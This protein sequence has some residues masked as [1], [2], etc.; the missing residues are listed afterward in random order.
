M[1]VRT[2]LTWPD[3]RLLQSAEPVEAVDD[4][5]KTLVADMFETMYAQSGCGL[6]ATQLGIPLQVVVLDCGT[7]AEPEP[8]ALINARIVERDGEVVWNEGCLSLPGITA[9]VERAETVVVEALD[10]EGREIRVRAGGLA[11]VCI[12][13]ELDHLDGRLYVDRLG[14]LERLAALSD[15]DKA[16][17]AAAEASRPARA[18]APEAGR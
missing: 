7:D 4:P 13:H 2:V 11:A 15:Y 9:D 5:I 12:Q 8:L 14:K 3:R 16:R 6:A 17:A 10:A 18:A 1:T